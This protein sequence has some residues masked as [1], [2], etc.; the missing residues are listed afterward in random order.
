[1]QKG[2]IECSASSQ[3][4]INAK[5]RLSG[6]TT[7]LD[8]AI[9]GGTVIDGTGSVRRLADVG[10]KGDRI[11]S[12]G[13][14]G[15]AAEEID[16][17]GKVV[18]PG[19]IDV[20]T[21]FDA[22]VFWDGHLTPS[23]LH[24]VTTALGGNCGFTI[25]PLSNDPSDADY[26]VRM[27]ARVEGMPLESLQS[28]VPWGEWRST[29]EYLDAVERRLGINAGFMAGHSAIRRVVMGQEATAREATMDEIAAMERLLHE[30]LD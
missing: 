14:V 19:F 17:R 2:A 4:T 22:Q 30:G 26:L 7:M 23:P 3:T 24:G 20:H 15:E 8:R 12:I 10:I 16:A 9:R 18:A 29:A 13:E 1:M 25:A 28:G 11:V 5:R 27:L 21:H 6:G